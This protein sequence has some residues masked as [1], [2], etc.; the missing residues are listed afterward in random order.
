[1]CFIYVYENKTMTH[2]EVVLRRDEGGWGRTMKGVNLIKIHHKYICKYHNESPI[3]LLYANKFFKEEHK[4]E[5]KIKSK[6]LTS[7]ISF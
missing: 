5:F 4:L 3:K 6:N 2:V 1:M 7:W